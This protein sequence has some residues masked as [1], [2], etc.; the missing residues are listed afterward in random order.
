SM[1]GIKT[2]RI[3]SSS[4][5]GL[6][7][8]GEVACTGVRG[9]NRL[10]SKSR[11]EGLCGGKRLAKWVKTNHVKENINLDFNLYKEAGEVALPKL[12]E[13]K[14]SMMDN[15]GIIRTKVGLLKQKQWLDN[16]H[17]TELLDANLEDYTTDELTKIFM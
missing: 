16:F 10:G 5:Q 13:I 17:I 2:D 8:I 4:L 11:M 15:V 14:D 6:Y 3:G 7:A 12:H 9:A 1:G